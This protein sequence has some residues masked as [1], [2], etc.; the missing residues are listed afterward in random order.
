ML[1][2]ARSERREEEGFANERLEG[3][4]GDAREV[5]EQPALLY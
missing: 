1:A 2:S 3:R 4:P 5:L